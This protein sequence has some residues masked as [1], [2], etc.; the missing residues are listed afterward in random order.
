MQ[1][2]EHKPELDG[3]GAQVVGVG[4]RE[5]FQARKL[6]S[7]GFPF[8]LL[9]D[10][11]DQVRAALGSAERFSPARLLDPRGAMPYLKAVRRAGKFFDI[12]LAQ[13]TQHPGVA[14]VNADLEVVWSYV[15][16]RLGDYPPHA[17]VLDELR[18]V[19]GR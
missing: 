17:L 12:T 19:A 6:G 14:V 18:K 3:L 10:P 13:A 1:L 5:D 11:E 2:R 15:G 4:A 16:Q 9:L 8:P 7:D